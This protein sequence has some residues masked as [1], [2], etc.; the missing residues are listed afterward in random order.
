[1]EHRDLAEKRVG[2]PRVSSLLLAAAALSL[3]LAAGC[4]LGGSPAPATAASKGK[5][6]PPDERYAFFMTGKSN[7]VADGYFSIGYVV[8]LLDADPARRLMIVGHADPHGRA[9]VN[10]ELALKRARA[11]RKIL[12]DHGIKDERIEVAAPRNQKEDGEQESLTRRADL[13]VFDPA[14]EDVGKRIGY[15]MEHGV[16]VIGEATRRGRPA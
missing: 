1:M 9:E 3:G 5:Y 11:V 8:A 4:T 12:V 2:P 13:Y 16:R 14:Q 7:V 10:R 15:P 6:D